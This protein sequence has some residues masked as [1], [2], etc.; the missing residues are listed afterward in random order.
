MNIQTWDNYDYKQHLGEEKNSGEIIVETAGYLDTEKIVRQMTM[1]GQRLQ[2]FREGYDYYE[3][4]PLE[5][6]TINPRLHYYDKIS[7]AETLYQMRQG[8]KAAAE[9][10]AATM[11]ERASHSTQ[12]ASGGVSNGGNATTPINPPDPA[13]GLPGESGRL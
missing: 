4:D 9:L 10:Y 13:T 1:A 5:A 8:Q 11:A 3:N 2:A 7:A 12:D 6:D